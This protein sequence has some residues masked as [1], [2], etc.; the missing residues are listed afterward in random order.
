MGSSSELSSPAWC[1]QKIITYDFCLELG[2]CGG[3]CCSGSTSPA[4]IYPNSGIGKVYYIIPTDGGST[5]IWW[6]SSQN[7]WEFS[8][9][10]GV[11]AGVYLNY[12]GEYPYSSS[13]NWSGEITEGNYFRTCDCTCFSQPNYIQPNYL[14]VNECGIITIHPMTIQC[15]PTAPTTLKEK[16]SLT[17]VINGGTPPY[18]VRLINPR[19]NRLGNYY[20]VNSN[21]I[22]IPNLSPGTYFIEV[23]D[24]F[25]DFQ[26]LIN[27]TVPPP[28]PTPTPTPTVTLPENSINF[29]EYTFCMQLIFLNK[30]T[31]L[32]ETIFCNFRVFSFT[33][34][35]NIPTP[36]WISSSQNEIIYFDTTFNYWRLSAS[37]SSN[38]VTTYL[39][40]YYSPSIWNANDWFILSNVGSSTV[41]PYSTPWSSNRNLNTTYNGYTFDGVNPIR[42]SRPS[43]QIPY[44]NLAINESW[45]QVWNANMPSIYRGSACGGNQTPPIIWQVFN[46]SPLT[47]LYYDILC[48]DQTNPGITYLDVTNI[49]PTITSI[50]NTTNWSSTPAVVNTPTASGTMNSQ[51]WKGPCPALSTQFFNITITVTLDNFSTLTATINFI[52][53][54]TIIN[55]VC[56]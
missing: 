37:T 3:G 33:L 40:P 52:T 38:L 50:N 25:G 55:G 49:P 41:Y 4:G 23:R 1:D 14:P 36:N 24:Q 30:E 11:Q 6:N 42:A 54:Q 34:I 46:I 26:Q 44:V 47:V 32:N 15:F 45:W 13:V 43:C 39:G 10:L 17:I 20:T 56:N 51:G 16:G 2:S 9:I 12:T 35:N 28:T 53:C 18:T 19:G 21:S 22:T 48:Y 29:F 7:R 27:C 8:V 5:Y 31:Q